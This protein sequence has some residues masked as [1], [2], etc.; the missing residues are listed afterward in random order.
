[1]AI[2]A[3]SPPSFSGNCCR[4]GDPPGNAL[5]HFPVRRA[6]VPG[7]RLDVST[8]IDESGDE[9]VTEADRDSNPKTEPPPLRSDRSGG[10]VFWECK[11][12]GYQR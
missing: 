10:G 12:P 7:E 4:N 2:F 8:R 5:D 6:A 1:M 3:V 11:S 9:N